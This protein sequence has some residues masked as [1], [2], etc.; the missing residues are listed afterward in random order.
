MHKEDNNTIAKKCIG[1]INIIAT[2]YFG[3]KEMN[4]ILIGMP[5]AG[6]STL[7]VLLAKAMNYRFVDTDLMIQ[8]RTGEFLYKTIEGRGIDE[9]LTI[10]E[11][12]LCGI[13]FD[14]TI[15]A[16]GGSA[17]YGE[18]AMNHLKNTGKIIYIKLSCD[19]I[20]RRVK[21]ITTRGIVMKKGKTLEDVFAERAPL[22]EKYADITVECDGISIEESVARI[23][24]MIS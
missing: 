14:R 5:G 8:E 15:I 24:N 9:F 22:Y 12:V 11:D 17:V 18:K 10:E 4:I 20:K 1:L 21:N 16:T 7:G 6:K 3:R 13:D 19:E 2:I 23:V